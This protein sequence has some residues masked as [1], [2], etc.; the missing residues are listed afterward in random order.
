ML[1]YGCKDR[2]A[3]TVPPDLAIAA[4]LSALR[5][6][7]LDFWSIWHTGKELHNFFEI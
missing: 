1:N 6:E 4:G 2:Y 7:R 3:E 5:R